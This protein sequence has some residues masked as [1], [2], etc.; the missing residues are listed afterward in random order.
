MTDSSN[1]NK[2]RNLK[3]ARNE[4]AK[5]VAG[6]ARVSISAIV[7]VVIVGGILFTLGWLGLR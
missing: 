4:E 7:A 1:A 3:I 6:S 2:A 5:Q